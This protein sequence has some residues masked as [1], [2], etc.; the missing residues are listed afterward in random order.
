MRN[1]QEFGIIHTFG[2]VGESY[3]WQLIYNPGAFIND[4]DGNQV[5]SKDYMKILGFNFSSSPDMAAQVEAIRKGFVARIWSLRHLRHRGLGED[6]LLKVYRSILLPVHD[7]CS[8]VNNSSL[9][10]TQASALERL[11]AQALKAIYGYE[12]SYRALLVRTG[13]QTLQECRDQRS[14]KFV[15]KCLVNPR[16]QAW[17]PPND[18]ERTTRNTIPYKEFHASTKRLYNSPLYHMRRRLNAR[19]NWRS[20]LLLL[21]KL[22]VCQPTHRVFCQTKYVWHLLWPELAK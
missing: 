19:S 8:C 14:D 7:Y 22:T 18:Q 13:L 16:F 12:H 4:T 3:S 10:L 15:Q 5:D 2:T 6:D 20:S 9:T 21:A 11:Q 17:F 1:L